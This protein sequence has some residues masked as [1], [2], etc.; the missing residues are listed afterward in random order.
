MY[1]QIVYHLVHQ[2]HVPVLAALFCPDDPH[3]R[4]LLELLIE[5]YDSAADHRG[6][7]RTILNLVRLD[8]QAWPAPAQE[9]PGAS[10][11]MEV[12]TQSAAAAASIPHPF[13]Q[14][15][16]MASMRPSEVLARQGGFFARLTR[17]MDAWHALLPRLIEDTRLIAQPLNG[18]PHNRR[19]RAPRVG[20]PPPLINPIST[21]SSRSAI[22]S[23]VS[24]VA[25]RSQSGGSPALQNSVEVAAAVQLDLTE[26]AD[27]DVAAAVAEVGFVVEGSKNNNGTSD[28]GVQGRGDFNNDDD[29]DDGGGN[30]TADDD[31]DLLSDDTAKIDDDW[32][33]VTDAANEA[34]IDDDFDPGARKNGKTEDVPLSI[35]LGSEYAVALGFHPFEPAPEGQGE[36]RIT[37]QPE[38][39]G[40]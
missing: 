9:E 28:N 3:A 23:S 19:P 26:I 13:S 14:S 7:V 6:F 15:S 36:S 22:K 16:S 38:P 35:D 30:E 11:D 12:S 18:K 32:P 37:W 24:R 27:P 4:P 25:A 17:D 40:A 8:I 1:F 39:V 31:N 29:G 33:N 21:T 20:L 10:Q 34:F 5:H 2:R